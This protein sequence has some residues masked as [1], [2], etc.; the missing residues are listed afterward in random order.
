MKTY[1]KHCRGDDPP[2]D[3]VQGQRGKRGRRY[4]KDKRADV[5]ACGEKTGTIVTLT[6]RR[7]DAGHSCSDSLSPIAGSLH[8]YRPL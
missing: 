1:G 5:W 6:Y 2:A 7:E 4:R 8:P 3:W